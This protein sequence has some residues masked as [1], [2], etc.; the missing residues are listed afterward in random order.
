MPRDYSRILV[1]GVGGF[2]GPWLVASLSE[3]FPRARLEA[4]RFRLGDKSSE[5]IQLDVRDAIA[6]DQAIAEFTPAHCRDAIPVLEERRL[7]DCDAQAVGQGPFMR[8]SKRP[9]LEF[10]DER[11]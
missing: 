2:V 6:V 4:T 5:N 10:D 11:R 1:T 3:R 8:P 7:L 9:V